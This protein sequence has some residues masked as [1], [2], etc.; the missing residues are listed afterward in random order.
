MATTPDPHV[1]EADAFTLQLERDPGL[2]A[3]IVAVAIFDRSPDWDRLVERVDRAT[4]LVPAFREKLVATPLGLAPPRWVPDP[5]F[6]LTWHLRRMRLQDGG[7]L[8]EL[9][10]LARTVGMDAFDHDR[11]LWEFTLVEGLA[12]GRAALVLKVHHALTDGIGGVEIAAHVVDLEREGSDLGPM[13]PVPS[14]RRSL[15]LEP[16]VEALGHDLRRVADLGTDLAR[17]LPGRAV[18]AIRDPVGTASAAVDEA[19]S[20][21]RMVRPIVDT[22]SPIMRDRRLQRHFS[23]LDIGFEELHDAAATVGATV[24]D[25]FVAAIAGGMRR[26]HEQHGATV[27]ELRVMMPI[28]FR[29]S[30]DGPGG[31]RV[32]LVRFEIPVHIFDPAERM[33][34]IHDICAEQ[35]REPALGHSEAIAGVLNRLPVG[36]TGGMLRHVDLLAS[37]VPGFDLAAYVAGAELEG[38]YPFGATLGSAVNITLMSYRGTCNVGVNADTGAVPDPDV[39]VASLRDGFD[40]V[41]AVG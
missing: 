15:P 30:G 41:L 5:D 39:F 29:R 26:Y 37:N 31:N 36:V 23:M 12:R 1:S 34:A 14:S 9:L 24:N 16:L 18:D 17:G 27:A 40:E 28:S 8:P 25:A 2:R 38:F 35:R 20:V 3:T 10:D 21:L 4:R 19:R 32:T 11:P 7:D 13:P 33:R 6:D 22:R